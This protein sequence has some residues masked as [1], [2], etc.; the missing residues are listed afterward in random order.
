M[1]ATTFVELTAEAQKQ[2]LLAFK[3]A[4]DLSLQGAELSVGLIRE[5]RA[6]VVGKLPTA[7][8]IVEGAFGFAGQVLQQQK[9]YA[10]QMT[11]L[12]T[13]AATSALRGAEDA[14]ASK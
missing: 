14:V 1:A 11:E 3:H 13:S 9:T 8:E 6:D 10:L 7:T 5:P 2:V 4:Q 12:M